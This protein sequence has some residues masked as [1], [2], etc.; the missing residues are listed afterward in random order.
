MS[1]EA[2]ERK[3]IKNREWARKNA[4]AN[5]VPTWEAFMGCHWRIES[6]PW[7]PRIL[8]HDHNYDCPSRMFQG[9]DHE[10]YAG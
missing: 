9:G 6:I 4:R 10:I 8:E 3:R 7:N 5:G 2:A 1:P